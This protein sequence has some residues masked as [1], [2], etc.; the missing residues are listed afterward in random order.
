MQ[1]RDSIHILH[2]DLSTTDT[3]SLCISITNRDIGMKQ[4]GGS[5]AWFSLFPGRVL[6]REFIVLF[7]VF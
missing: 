6:T 2:T 5:M 3:L 7:R 4:K 1:D